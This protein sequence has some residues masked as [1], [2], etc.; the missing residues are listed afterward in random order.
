[1]IWTGETFF[2]K[3][4]FYEKAHIYIQPDINHFFNAAADYY[5]LLQQGEKR[6]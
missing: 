5:P 6:I 2:D 1:M 4:C 3:I